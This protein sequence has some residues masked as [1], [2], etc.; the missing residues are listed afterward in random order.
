MAVKVQSCQKLLL[1]RVYGRVHAWTYR[2]CNIWKG[3][4][5][6]ISWFPY[7]VLQ[8]VGYE[9]GWGIAGVNKVPAIGFFSFSYC[10]QAQKQDNWKSPALH[11]S[12]LPR[13]LERALYEKKGALSL[14]CLPGSQDNKAKS[15]CIDD[16]LFLT[17]FSN[18]KVLAGNEKQST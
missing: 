14:S 12:V 13:A 1:G 18:Q 4:W 6:S 16:I 10:S 15:I 7:S 2:R 8:A 9:L 11:I 3:A 17:M 5:K